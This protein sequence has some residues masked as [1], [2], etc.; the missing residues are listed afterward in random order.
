MSFYFVTCEFNAILLREDWL[1]GYDAVDNNPSGVKHIRR[2]ENLCGKRTRN[3]LFIFPKEFY[4]NLWSEPELENIKMF[5]R[6]QMNSRKSSVD[7]F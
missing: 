5:I 1:S 3:I 4:L 6:E 7:A 2:D